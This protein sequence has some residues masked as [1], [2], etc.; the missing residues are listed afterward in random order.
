MLKSPDTPVSLADA[1]TYFADQDNA[2]RFLAELRWPDGVKCPHCQADDPGFL[3][4]RR[5]WKCRK[6]RKQFSIKV[7]TIFEDSPLGLDKWLPALWMLANSKNGISSYEVARAI[8]VTQ[9]TAWFMLGRIRAAM[10]HAGGDS[11]DGEVEID[12]SYVG[13]KYANM[14]LGKRARLG[15]GGAG[16]N[17]AVVFGI[18]ERPKGKHG[19]SRIR[20]TVVGRDTTSVGYLGH[21]RRH[22]KRGTL[23]YSDQDPNFGA[24]VNGYTRRVI[25]HAH[26]Y[27]RGRIHTNGIENFWSLLKRTI[28]GTYVSIDPFHVFRYLDEQAFR[29]HNRRASDGD[30][31][32][33]MVD[34]LLGKRLTYRQ[35]TGADLATT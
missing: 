1:C 18:L 7:G 2:L 5:I 34:S 19:V 22:V 31:F 21:V 11:F 29:F 33:T 3:K 16:K 14:H 25:N 20:T 28:N 4:S 15:S 8:H 32:V 35:L 6:C 30:R 26:A 13:G 9:K 23:V 12:E 27:V 24:L 10:A 17:K